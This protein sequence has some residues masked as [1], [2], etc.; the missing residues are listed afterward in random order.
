ME[1]AELAELLPA[2]IPGLLRYATAMVRDTDLAQDL[3]GDTCVR[4][5]ERSESFRAESSL[6]TWLHRILHNLAVD[7]A[8]SRREVPDS[9]IAAEVEK[10]WQD[11]DY[12][13]DAAV[14]VA[15]AETSAEL[16]DALIRLPYTHRAAVVLHDAH[17][18]TAAEIAEVFDIS[19]P[20]AKQ[21]LRR[22]R[23]MLVTALANGVERRESV[24]GVPLSCWE[25]RRHVS[26]YLD[27]DVDPR[28]AA[29]LEAHLAGCPT[30][31][32]LYRSLVATTEA[33][34]GENEAATRDPDSTI[35]PAL[36]SRLRAALS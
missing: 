6:A 32:A 16:H 1:Q 5:L 13:V 15:R 28:T 2:E 7:R 25:A 30:C 9:D 36:Q 14:V 8:R 27:N 19:L 4:A 31:P 11:N 3:V 26:D 23:M 20:A 18:L 34:A 35:P 33:L 17:G 22:G 29:A 12:T 21:R 10:R 24:R